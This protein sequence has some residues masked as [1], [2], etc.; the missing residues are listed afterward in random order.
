MTGVTGPGH[1]G[2]ARVPV[3]ARCRQGDPR[4][5][6]YRVGER[7]EAQDRMR[8]VKGGGSRVRGD[9]GAQGERMRGPQ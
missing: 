4:R 6:L 7:Q 8:C 1:G 3:G 5:L 2:W 9:V